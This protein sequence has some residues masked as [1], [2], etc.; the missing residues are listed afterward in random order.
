[1]DGLHVMVLVDIQCAYLGAR[2]LPLSD[3]FSKKV[4]KCIFCRI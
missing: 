3:D 2:V 1:M 4:Q